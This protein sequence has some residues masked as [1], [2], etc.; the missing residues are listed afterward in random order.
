[1]SLLHEASP[2]GTTAYTR[3]SQ[4][5]FTPADTV[6]ACAFSTDFHVR[7]AWDQ[8]IDRLISIRFL[9]DDWDGEGSVAPDPSAVAGATKLALALKAQRL[10]PAD[11]VTASVNGTVVFEWHTP[12]GYHEI[13]ITSPIDAESRWVAKGSR[14]A[15]ITAISLG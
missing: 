5:P 1:M 9:E 6:S 10:L 14:T 2:G 15:E 13:E 11:R 7:E 12:D 8:L 4:S 3:L